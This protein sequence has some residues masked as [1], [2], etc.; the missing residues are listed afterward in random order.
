MQ[1]AVGVLVPVPFLVSGTNWTYSL[2]V[3]VVFK[4]LRALIK[5]EASQEG[6]LAG[7][8]GS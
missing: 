5:E 8:T 2:Q 4:V 1:N 6:S 7:R 3:G